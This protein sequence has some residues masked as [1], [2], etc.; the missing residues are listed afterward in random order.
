M[1]GQEVLIVERIGK[2]A[3]LVLDFRALA[4]LAVTRRAIF[5]VE[6][7]TC[8]NLGVFAAGNRD[9]LGLG[10]SRHD[11]LDGEE[12]D[13]RDNGNHHEAGDGSITRVTLGA[14]VKER[15]AEQPESDQHAQPH[16]CYALELAGEVLQELEHPQEVPLRPRDVG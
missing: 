6:L 16:D 5:R 13:A 1:G 14:A 9:G 7:L 11:G 10:R 15:Q 3:R 12:H 8:G 2:L 4:C